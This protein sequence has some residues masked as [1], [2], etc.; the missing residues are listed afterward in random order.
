M[1]AATLLLFLVLGQNARP[2][3]EEPPLQLRRVDDGVADRDA[4]SVSFRDPRVSLGGPSG[5][6]EVFSPSGR[7][8]LF[9]RGSGAVYATFR[10]SVYTRSKE[11][12]TV[13]VVPGGTIFSIGLP[14]MLPAASGATSE[15][16][17]FTPEGLPVGASSGVNPFK[18]SGFEPISVR[19]D[20]NL[21]A[22][23]A[24]ASSRATEPLTARVGL[25]VHGGLT[26]PN[27]AP[28]PAAGA[29]QSASESSD[30]THL[31]I[32]L[33][34]SRLDVDEPLPRFLRD[35]AYRRTRLDSLLAALSPAAR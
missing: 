9:M 27:S 14:R 13:I 30:S 4:L 29:V 3:A 26:R 34:R 2:P 22:D 19:V 1:L 17:R 33:P 5:F 28:R 23:S 15:A 7:D 24:V 10:R 21:R 20:H 6:R 25:E 32:D 8:D 12:Q 18:A 31:H 16:A 11:N 35:E